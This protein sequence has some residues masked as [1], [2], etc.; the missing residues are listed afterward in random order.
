MKVRDPLSQIGT[1][2]HIYNILH[3]FSEILLDS[4]VNSRSQVKNF[5]L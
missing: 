3:E 5:W 4:E 2:T 1:K